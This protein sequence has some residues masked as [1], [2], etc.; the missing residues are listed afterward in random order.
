MKSKFNYH[1][2]VPS[3]VPSISTCLLERDYFF[4][5]NTT[6]PNFKRFL[7]FP[8]IEAQEK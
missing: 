1:S 4:F 3:V 6:I 2:V 5:S 7:I 8:Y